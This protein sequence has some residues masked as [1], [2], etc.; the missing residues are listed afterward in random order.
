MLE[1]LQSLSPTQVTIL[2]GVLASLLQLAFVKGLILKLKT[3]TDH[4]KEVI[5][6]VMSAVIPALLVVGSSLATN[7]T[8][9]NTFPHYAESYLVAQAFYYTVVRFF[10]MVYGW[11]SLAKAVKVNSAEVIL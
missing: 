11:Y 3:F 1:V 2:I 10:K 9:T 7:S 5:N 8:F 4:H 6:V